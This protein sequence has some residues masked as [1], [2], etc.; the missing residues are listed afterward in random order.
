[1][2]LCLSLVRCLL[3]LCLF[4]FFCAFLFL[5][6]PPV[7]VLFG[8]AVAR[9]RR[10][11]ERRIVSWDEANHATVAC[12]KRCPGRQ[13]PRRPVRDGAKA[14]GVAT[15]LWCR[16]GRA[17]TRWTPACGPHAAGPRRGGGCRRRQG[18]VVRRRPDRNRRWLNSLPWLVSTGGWPVVRGLRCCTACATQGLVCVSAAE[19]REVSFKCYCCCL[20]SL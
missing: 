14:A 9:A 20:D 8:R 15:G 5:R 19:L 4:V 7:F 13:G 10:C 3:R 1:M 18:S 2:L 16:R 17:A 12:G 11:G 6:P